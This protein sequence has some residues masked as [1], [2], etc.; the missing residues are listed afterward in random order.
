[1]TEVHFPLILDLVEWVKRQPRTYSDVMDVWRTSCPRL[2]V[3][4]DAIDKGYLERQHGGYLGETVIVTAAGRQLL[5]ENGRTGVPV[6]SPPETSPQ[7]G[8]A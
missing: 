6:I 4:E 1:M 7:L 5:V 8:S 3:W 2:P